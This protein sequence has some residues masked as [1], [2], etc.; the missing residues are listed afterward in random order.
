[1]H[2]KVIKQLQQLLLYMYATLTLI[3]SRVSNN[4]L[5]KQCAC[6]LLVSVFDVASW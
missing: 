4:E 5:Q 1:M 2:G 3:Q 6:T